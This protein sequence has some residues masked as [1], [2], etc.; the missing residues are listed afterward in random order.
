VNGVSSFL[1]TLMICAIAALGIA[2]TSAQPRTTYSGRAFAA[3]VNTAVTGPIYLSDSGS[4]P[5][6][7]G[8][9]GNSLLS[10]NVPGVL[11]A[12]VLVASTSGAS[13]QANSSASLANATVLQG[14]P[15]ELNAS[16]VR[17]QTQ[18]NCDAVSGSSE[19]AN[20]RFMGQN[21]TV[22]G[23]PNQTITVPGVATLIIN[24]QTRAQ[25][26]NYHQI[27]VNAVHLI[28]NGIA[29]VI[30]ASSESDINC[31]RP[32]EGPCHDFVTGGGWIA[33]AGGRGNFGFNVGFKDHSNVPMAHFNYIDRSANV[34]LKATSVSVY[35]GT[36]NTRHFEGTCQVNG[37][38]G[39]T[40]TCDVTDNGEPG[41]NDTLFLT[42]SNGYAA[43]GTL[44]GGNIQLHSPCH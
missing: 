11:A 7:G 44:Q 35:S 16:F 19:L 30:L 12:D 1:R 28:V 43:G 36:G 4:L 41:R 42:I 20:V 22:T 39:F 27:R 25:K 6:S 15:Y 8:V 29:E 31:G 21:I 40:F 5:P 2:S 24:E 13:N 38:A 10:A 33:T 37:Q 32:S 14:S 17:S 3:F 34:H 23:Q 26:G 18:A 9:Q